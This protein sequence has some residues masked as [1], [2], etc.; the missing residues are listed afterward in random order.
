MDSRVQLVEKA[1]EDYHSIPLT[2]LDE[3]DAMLIHLADHPSLGIPAPVPFRP[4]S[5]LY[6]FKIDNAITGR[7][8]FQIRYR[9]SADETS[10]VVQRIIAREYL[11]P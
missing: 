3:V 5:L 7:L 8:Y 6:D 2:I 11:N 9:R 1:I 4:G 10:I